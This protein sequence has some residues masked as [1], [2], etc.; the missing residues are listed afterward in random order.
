MKL[1]VQEKKE[2]TV[3]DEQLQVVTVYESKP[4]KYSY[5]VFIQK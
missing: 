5:I 3:D 4:K 1:W 2:K